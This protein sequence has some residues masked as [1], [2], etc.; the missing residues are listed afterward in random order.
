MTPEER[1]AAWKAVDIVDGEEAAQYLSEGEA[2]LKRGLLRQ[3]ETDYANAL[4]RLYFQAAPY[5]GV[6][7]FGPGPDG[8]LNVT[9]RL[10]EGTPSYQI[11]SL[12]FEEAEELFLEG[13]ES[14]QVFDWAQSEK[15]RFTLQRFRRTEVEAWA[16]NR[17]FWGR[18][19]PDNG[20]TLN[21]KEKSALLRVIAVLAASCGLRLDAHSSAAARLEQ[22]A[23][24]MGIP[25]SKRTLEKHLRAAY[26]ETGRR[27]Q[28]QDD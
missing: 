19:E 22:T 7:D 13:G 15:S 23:A 24:E 4:R 9:R 27:A 14:D 1:V 3:L 2:N 11:R 28:I 20:G 5:V 21:P 25:I 6:E 10:P 26:E 8:N 12:A 17:G 18:V 16:E